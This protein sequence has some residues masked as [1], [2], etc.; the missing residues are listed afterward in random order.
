MPY[1]RDKVDT[2]KQLT[3]L[4]GHSVGFK[5]R[6]LFPDGLEGFQDGMT[7]EEAV[8]NTRKLVDSGTSVIY[9]AAFIHNQVLVITD[10]LVKENGKYIGY[11]VKSSLKVSETYL[12]DACLQYYVMN[13]C[14]AA[15]EDMFL[16]TIHPDYRAS[17]HANVRDLFKKRS[18]KEK[19]LENYAFFAFKVDAAKQLLEK[20]IVPDRPTGLHC[21]RP[22]QCDYFGTCWKNDLSEK[23]VFHLPLIDKG[24]LLEWF[25]S[26][27]KTFDQV[28]NEVIS[29]PIHKRIKEALTTNEVVLDKVNLKQWIA[30]LEGYTAAFDIEVWAP[31]IPE[32]E[33]TRPFEQIPFLISI[34]NE[35]GTFSY[36]ADYVTDDR[37]MMASYICEKLA[38]Y[39]TLLVYDKT[40]EV[41]V[42][43][44]LANLFPECRDDLKAIESKIVDVFDVVING[45]YYHPKLLNNFSLKKLSSLISEEQYTDV[46]S[47]LEAMHLFTEY[48]SQENAIEKEML[49]ER[50]VHYCE[51]DA[52][53]T[54][55]ITRYFQTLI[56]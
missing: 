23:S 5:A 39:D 33:G 15:F 51:L 47:G 29:K 28:P 30:K 19:A 36:L 11:E 4:R 18:V 12:K 50:L 55:R 53:A 38:H 48:R 2:D 25:H 43:N 10:M 40:L 49:R 22:Y 26:G 34:Y 21:F 32:L 13:H 35:N 41:S 45:W 7:V 54:F 52:Q 16:V 6:E 17:P 3:F 56:K 20:G 42:L 14:L 37:K 31:A 9:E 27:W 46:T 1:L 8:I 44:Q 24:I